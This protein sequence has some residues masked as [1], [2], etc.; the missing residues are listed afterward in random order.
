M[1][2]NTAKII[3]DAIIA[4]LPSDTSLHGDTPHQQD[5]YIPPSHSKALHLECSL[6]IGAR[7]VGKTFWSA[8]LQSAEI[9]TMIGKSVPNFENVTV[10]AGFGEKTK[11]DAYPGKDIFKLLMENTNN[12]AYDIWRAVLARWLSPIPQH[13]ATV[14][15]D[16]WESTVNW[17]QQNPEPF[18]RLLEGANAYFKSENR[19]DMIV[20]DALDR[21]STDWQTMDTIVRDLLQVMLMLKPFSHL[22]G[23]VFLREDQHTRTVTDFPDASKIRATTVHLTWDPQDLY[24]MLWQTLCNGQNEHGETLRELYNSKMPIP[25]AQVNNVW[26]VG[27]EAKRAGAKQRELFT[28]LAGNW[29]GNNAKRGYTYTWTVGHLA[30]G[31]GRT[32]PRS[33]RKAIRAAAENT[34]DRYDEHAYALHYESIKY[35]VQQ[36]SQIRVD[37]LAEDYP[38]I[39]RLM[40]PLKG[41]IVPC[42]FETIQKQ[43]VHQIGESP[44]ENLAEGLPPEHSKEGWSGIRKDVE[45]LGIFISMKDER[46]NMPDLFRV[47]FGLG[48]KGGVKPILKNSGN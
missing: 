16:N 43:W 13:T 4:S 47:G 40:E 30:D 46:I 20:F 45:K 26:I 18:S 32:S 37:E 28:A 19:V 35:G 34:K 36:A 23:K 27:N 15:C 31:Q 22:Y 17:V 48:R 3:R 44:P 5:V 1:S 8:A 6:I 7:G 9:R 42:P 12:T 11:T 10:N 33:F 39:H 41:T 38:W 29:M 21:I 24:G 25:I 2:M 14:P